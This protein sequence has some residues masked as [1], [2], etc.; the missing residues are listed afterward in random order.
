MNGKKNLISLV[1]EELNKFI[2]EGREYADEDIVDT[3]DIN[4]QHEYDKLNQQLFNNELPKVLLIW[5]NRKR[6]LG[7]VRA[8]INRSTGDIKIKHLAMSAFYKTPYRLFKNTLAHEMIHVKTYSEGKRD[9]SGSHGF[10]FL[11]EARRI[12]DMGLGFT[13]TAVNAEEV[14][15]SDRVKTNMKTLIGMIFNID[16][17][18][19]L[20]VTTPNVFNAE[21]DNVFNLFEKLVNRGKYRS[22]E[23]TVVETKNPQLVSYRVARSYKRGFSYGKLSDAL[24]GELLDDKIIKNIKINP[25]VPRV[26][27]E[28]TELPDNSGDWEIIDIV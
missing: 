14:A 12:N 24:L 15:V 26:V 21:A 3:N 13:I 2:S 4:L 27:S 17:N 5:S 1:N 28:N 18:Y 7:H 20:S 19:Y 25:G 23:I 16:G 11:N 22:V 6:A 9:W 10:V 8:M